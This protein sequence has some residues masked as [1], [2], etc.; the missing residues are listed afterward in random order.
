MTALRLI[1]G[2]TRN[3]LTIAVTD[4]VSGD[5]VDIFGSELRF[6]IRPSPSRPETVVAKTS[7]DGGITILDT[8]ANDENRG[9]AQVNFADDDWVGYAYNTAKFSWDLQEIFDGKTETI[10]GTPLGD[11]PIEIVQ[12]VTWD[13][14]A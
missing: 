3:P 1:R 7:A 10:A 8:G 13:P 14:E 11:E 12:D 4:P 5:P 9:K 6:T 2:D